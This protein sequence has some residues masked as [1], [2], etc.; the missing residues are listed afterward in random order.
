MAQNQCTSGESED[1][2]SQKV[3]LKVDGVKVEIQR[4]RPKDDGMHLT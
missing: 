2:V 1:R 3:T 4:R